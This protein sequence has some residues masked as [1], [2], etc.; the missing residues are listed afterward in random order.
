MP[1]SD[2]NKVAGND[3]DEIIKEFFQTVLYRCQKGL[4]QSMRGS[5]FVFNQR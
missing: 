3:T 1:K 5:K 2:F 4:E